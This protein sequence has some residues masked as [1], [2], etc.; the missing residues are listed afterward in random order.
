MDWKSITSFYSS[1]KILENRTRFC[2]FLRKAIKSIGCR[3]V[4]FPP[5][6]ENSSVFPSFTFKTSEK[7]DRIFFAPKFA[8]LPFAQG[9]WTF[10]A[11][12]V[13][14][15]WKFRDINKGNGKHYW[16]VGCNFFTLRTCQV[17][18]TLRKK[19]VL[20]SVT[21]FHQVHLKNVFVHCTL[22]QNEI[23]SFRNY[24]Y[25]NIVKKIRKPDK[26]NYHI[27]FEK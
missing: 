19:R 5:I 17:L 22:V 24:F 10:L 16:K 18:R 20:Q 26:K 27:F 14:Q 6:R 23:I 7:P 1:L 12:E 8:I 3:S 25:R 4:L 21:L 2:E 15:Y 9:I 13:W 11:L